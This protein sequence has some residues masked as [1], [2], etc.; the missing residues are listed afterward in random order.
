MPLV[1]QTVKKVPA[2]WETQ[3]RGEWRISS[4][5]IVQRIPW[6][7]E[8]GGLQSMGLQRVGHNW[9][10]HTRTHAQHRACLARTTQYKSAQ[11]SGTALSGTRWPPGSRCHI[12]TGHG[13][14]QKKQHRD[15]PSLSLSK[16]W[17]LLLWKAP[18]QTA[19]TLPVGQSL[20]PWPFPAPREGNVNP[21]HYFCL[22]KT[23]DRGAWQATY[24]GGAKSQ[25]Q[26]S[27]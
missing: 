5:E 23:M 12:T 17:R 10:T 6:T 3:D 26:L 18:Q 19:P 9:V 1:A 8:V 4:R 20:C 21:L 27:N 24:H 16:D 25:T 13:S 14:V 2:M 7:G 22:E 15:K 11:P